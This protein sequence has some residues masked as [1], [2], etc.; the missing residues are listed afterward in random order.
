MG[1]VIIKTKQIVVPIYEAY[2]TFIY[3][4]SYDAIVKYA[5]IDGLNHLDIAYLKN[6]DYEGYH[7]PLIDK[8]NV[9]EYYLIVKKNGDKYQEVDTIAHEISHLVVE[10]LHDAGV[11]FS[12]RND[13]PYAYL[14]GYLTKEFFKFKD[15]K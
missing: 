4:N 9:K 13:E 8:D 10:I 12:I 1:K 6:K 15:S 3:S 2:V 7:L 5:T 14:T 11:K